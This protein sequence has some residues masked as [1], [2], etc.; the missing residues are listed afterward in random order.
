M[1]RS[2][3][4]NKGLKSRF[5]CDKK[6][7]KIIQKKMCQFVEENQK[8]ILFKFKREKLSTIRSFGKL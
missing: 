7:Y 3:L 6:S 5:I 1:V 2:K 8:S 4:K